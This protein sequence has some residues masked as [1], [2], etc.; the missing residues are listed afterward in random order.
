VTRQSLLESLDGAELQKPD[1]DRW[2]GSFEGSISIED[3]QE[4][5]ESLRFDVVIPT[6]EFDIDDYIWKSGRESGTIDKVVLVQ[7]GTVIE[8]AKVVA[9]AREGTDARWIP[10][11]AEQYRVSFEVPRTALRRDEP[12]VLHVRWFDQQGGE[13]EDL[14]VASNWK[15]AG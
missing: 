13:W 12:L 5:V 3:L 1:A 10:S 11:E 9:I 8:E 7:A 15:A 14:A 4:R 6:A 2:R